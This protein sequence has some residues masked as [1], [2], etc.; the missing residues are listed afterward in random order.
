MEI[1]VL[2]FLTS[3]FTNSIPFYFDKTWTE[4]MIIDIQGK[5]VVMLV[6]I[7]MF[8]NKLNDSV[9]CVCVCVCLFCLYVL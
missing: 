7:C 6:S 3:F 9:V 4:P 2:Y 1:T 8:F 5:Q